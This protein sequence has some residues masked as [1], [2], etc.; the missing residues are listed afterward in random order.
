MIYASGVIRR[1]YHKLLSDKIENTVVYYCGRSADIAPV[2]DNCPPVRMVGVANSNV[3][4]FEEDPRP[5]Q[6]VQSFFSSVSCNSSGVRQ[7]YSEI[8]KDCG[9]YSD[10]DGRDGRNIVMVNVNKATNVAEDRSY[11]G[12]RAFFITLLAYVFFCLCL[13]GM[14]FR[15]RNK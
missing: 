7:T 2:E 14:F 15:K 3:N 5:L 4:H 6:F 10:Y 8:A 13:G 12:G 11:K 1:F 9:K